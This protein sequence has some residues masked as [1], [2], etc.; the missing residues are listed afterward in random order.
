MV[1]LTAKQLEALRFVVAYA[2]EHSWMPTRQEVADALGV[3]RST[4][5]Q[6]LQ[7]CAEKG[8]IAIEARAVGGITVLK[9]PS[10]I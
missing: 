9:V 1:P 8:Y 6:R 3:S 4:A 5:N 2:R 10:E 7:A